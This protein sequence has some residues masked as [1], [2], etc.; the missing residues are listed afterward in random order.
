VEIRGD[1]SGSPGTDFSVRRAG[2]D[3]W[4]L[5]ARTPVTAP[6]L[7][8]YPDD[9]ARAVWNQLAVNTGGD[10][11]AVGSPDRRHIT[12]QRYDRVRQ[13]W[14]TPHAVLIARGATCRRRNLDSGVLQ[15]ATF[16]LRL[17]CDGQLVELRSRTGAVW[18]TEHPAK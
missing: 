10:L 12:V 7:A 1:V 16:R 9:P 2:A 17:V 8:V 6:G 11:V 13:E 18:S 14:T 4:S 15:G 5:T 3:R